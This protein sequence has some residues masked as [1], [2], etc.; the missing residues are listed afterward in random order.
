MHVP[1]DPAAQHAQEAFAILQ[2]CAAAF[3]LL[4]A[5]VVASWVGTDTVEARIRIANNVIAGL[6]T[7]LVLFTVTRR[8]NVVWAARLG[9][10]VIVAYQGV[11]SYC[12][13]LLAMPGT[14][15]VA[16]PV[17]AGIVM[18]E[19]PVAAGLWGVGIAV[20]SAYG[21][22]VEPRFVVETT[23]VPVAI[24]LFATVGFFTLYML[25]YRH[26]MQRV[27]FDATRAAE[28]L[29]RTNA[30]LRTTMAERDAL[31]GQLATAQ[32]LEAMGRVAGGIA[33]DFNN[34]LTVIRG[35][36]DLLS[37]TLPVGSPQAEDARQLQ[38][39]LA[40]ASRVTQDVLDFARPKPT[41]RQAMDLGA[42][43]R[44]IAPGLS[45]VSGTTHPLLIRVGDGPLVVEGN[46]AQLERLMVN[47][48]LNARDASPAGSPIRLEIARGADAGEPRVTLSVSDRGT[49]VPVELHDRIFE[50]FFT[51]KGTTGGTGLGLATSFALVQQ[52]GGTLR[53][54]N[55]PEGGARF[56]AS[57][58][59]HAAEI[60]P[61]RSS[62]DRELSPVL[63]RPLDGMRA[64]V[65]EDDPGVRAITE[66]L[67][68]S[69][70]AEV[71]AVAHGGEG[72]ASVRRHVANDDPLQ[73][74]VSDLRL[75]VG[76][77]KDVLR[78]ARA[79]WP[80][81]ALV[82]ISGFLEDD[83]V[84]AMAAARELVFLPKPFTAERLIA[85]VEEA[86]RRD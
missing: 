59:A 3:V 68:R 48:I 23:P 17:L 85:A 63:G 77:G 15:V 41:D 30:S 55:R 54:E 19:R 43:V 56:V 42:F 9:A 64:L 62:L 38:H 70:G 84:A 57:F 53:V 67:L 5:G 34:L 86:R 28:A 71:E 21:V 50:P 80:S 27:V 40:R 20:L 69:A 4:Q 29:E 16:M 37:R 76:S 65:V 11:I 72:L 33:H 8:G 46:R 49:G 58:P 24:A 78:A 6:C 74:V 61:G 81:A 45:A 18:T 75:P 14:L 26:A 73:L 1:A 36:S 31:A 66:R 35:Y 39:A 22:L 32:R 51:T 7:A 13:G 12:F 82:A 79:S 44:D 83:D 2:G 25:E 10:M 47:L 60:A 52:H